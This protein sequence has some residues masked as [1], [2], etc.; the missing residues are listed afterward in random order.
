MYNSVSDNSY[1]LASLLG[2]L[3][4]DGFGTLTVCEVPLVTCHVVNERHHVLHVF[5]SLSCE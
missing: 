5:L 2:V 3:R 4:S 1:C